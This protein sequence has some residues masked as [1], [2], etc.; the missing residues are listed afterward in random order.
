MACVTSLSCT[1]RYTQAL[2]LF[3]YPNKQFKKGYVMRTLLCVCVHVCV[4]V[5]QV[6]RKHDCSPQ[7]ASLGLL[8]SSRFLWSWFV[9]LW[10]RD[11]HGNRKYVCVFVQTLHFVNILPDISCTG[12]YFALHLSSLTDT[13]CAQFIVAL[14]K[15]RSVFSSPCLASASCTALLSD[16]GEILS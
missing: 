3:L 8:F 2:A 11:R 9:D 1:M 5:L 15:C 10:A 16:T 14:K 13:V 6:L 7:P 4:H 12:V